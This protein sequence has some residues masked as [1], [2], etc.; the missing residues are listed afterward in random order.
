VDSDNRGGQRVGDARKLT[1]Q[2]T[3]GTCRDRNA[4]NNHVHKCIPKEAISG[5]SEFHFGRGS[6][7]C[8][9][10]HWLDVRLF[11]NL[12]ESGFRG[13]TRDAWA[14]VEILQIS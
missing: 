12:I 8:W 5:A 4:H 13:F 1:S 9:S 2:R 11:G 7:G 6:L 3:A 14:G 10:F